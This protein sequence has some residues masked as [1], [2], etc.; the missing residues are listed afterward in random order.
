MRVEWLETALKNLE[1]EANYI[2]LENP[3]AADD[4]SEAIFSSVDKLA[5]NDGLDR[6]AIAPHRPSNNSP[7]LSSNPSGSSVL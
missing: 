6:S 1:D 4:F 2:A 7:A 5:S 3:Q